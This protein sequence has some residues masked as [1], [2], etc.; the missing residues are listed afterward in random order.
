METAALQVVFYSTGH[1]FG[2]ASRDFEVVRAVHALAPHATLHLR[3]SVAPWFIA[4]SLD[5][6]PHH[7]TLA[8]LDVGISQPNSITQDLPATAEACEAL[9]ARRDALITAERAALRDLGADLVVSDIPAVPFA[10]AEAEGIAAV[11]LGNFTWS[12]IYRHLVTA[13]PRLGPVADAF[14]DD[15]RRA[16]TL[17]RLPF[18]GGDEVAAPFRRVIDLPMVARRSRL[19]VAEARRRLGLDA[20]RPTALLSFGG[21][22]P[23]EIDI[24]RL[25]RTPD[26][27]FLITPPGPRREEPNVRVVGTDEMVGRGLRFE[28][29]VRACDV[30]A[31]KP[32]YGIVSECIVNET[33][34]LYTS[35]GAFAEYPMLVKGIETHGVSR[36]I[37]NE[38]LRAGDWSDALD[39][40]M[41]HPRRPCAV[42]SDGAATAARL[43]MERVS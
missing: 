21:L 1:G 13:E 22:G 34:L 41:R 25:S 39:D 6:V 4:A 10:A 2:H 17:L 5:G 42:A 15:Y 11:A 27:L 29:L 35:R 16:G 30:V 43:L 7:V 36:F 38:T 26:W 18:H 31:S 19:D 33:R 14:D 20:F 37:D 3:T 24:D 28:D 9:L 40:L 32:G 23:S 12:W 8:T